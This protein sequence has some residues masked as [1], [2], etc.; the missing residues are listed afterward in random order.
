MTAFV[1]VDMEDGLDF[2]ELLGLY[3]R[4]EGALAS[5]LARPAAVVWGVEAYTGPHAKAAALLDAL[6]RS[7][8]LL[9]GN[10]RLSWTMTDVLYRLHG[11]R[12]VAEPHDVDAFVR[13]VGGDDHVTLEEI[14]AWL[15]AHAR[16]LDER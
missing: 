1:H 13:S 5:A 10:K 14:A 11:H 9:D 8:P 7:R 16:P 15:E 2:C 6:N 4:D 3:I 12:L